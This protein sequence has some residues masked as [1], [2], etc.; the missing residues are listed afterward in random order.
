MLEYYVYHLID[1]RNGLPFYVGK[2]RGR[3][4]IDHLM[5]S[6]PHNRKTAERVA[7]IRAIGHEPRPVIVASFGEDEVAAYE[8]EAREIERIGPDKLTNVRAR[9]PWKTADYL[10]KQRA[11]REATS[12]S[13]EDR[14][15]LLIEARI[16]TLFRGARYGW[17]IWLYSPGA[18]KHDVP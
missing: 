7:S 18:P 10:A 6:A 5:P 1:P 14:M 13:A 16:R 8:A 11:R 2:G 17:N 4:L 15:A 3:R 9:E 12:M